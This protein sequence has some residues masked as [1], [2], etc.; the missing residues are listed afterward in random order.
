L[1]CE[2]AP[3][4]RAGLAARFANDPKIRAI[5]DQWKGT[6]ALDSPLEKSQDLKMVMLEETPWLRQATSM[7]GAGRSACAAPSIAPSTLSLIRNMFLDPRQRTV[8]IG[9]WISS[10]SVGSAIGPLLGGLMLVR[11]G[12]GSVFLAGS[13]TGIGTPATARRGLAKVGGTTASVRNIISGNNFSGVIISGTGT[14]TNTV[15]GNQ[16]VRLIEN[17]YQSSTAITKIR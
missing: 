4:V 10:Y 15:A 13:F 2:A 9:V 16:C 3:R 17:T 11:F 12:W 5:F 8:A 7:S 6:P 14:K 1:L